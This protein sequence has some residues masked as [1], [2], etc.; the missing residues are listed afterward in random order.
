MTTTFVTATGSVKY[1]PFRE[2]SIGDGFRWRSNA[3]IKTAYGDQGSNALCLD[4]MKVEVMS[5]LESVL[6]INLKIT[7]E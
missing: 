4:L 5:A 7:E 1:K 3:Y 6:P 2:L